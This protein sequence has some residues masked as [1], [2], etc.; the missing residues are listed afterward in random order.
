LNIL[1]AKITQINPLEVYVEQ[2]FTLPADFLIVPESL[3]KLE[4]K[5]E[6]THKYNDSSGTGSTTRSTEK[7]DY[8]EPVVIRRGLEIGDNVLLLRLSGGQQYLILDRMV[9]DDT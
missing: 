7:A 1:F 3:M 5:L 4:L 8:A 6:H 9:T 2:R